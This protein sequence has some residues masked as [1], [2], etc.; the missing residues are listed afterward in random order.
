MTP[1]MPHTAAW[2]TFT[3]VSFAAAAAMLALGIF[4]LPADTWIKGYLERHPI[5]L[6]CS[7]QRRGRLGTRLARSGSSCVG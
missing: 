3:L 6:R 5:R 4:F 2:K 7:R 1:Q